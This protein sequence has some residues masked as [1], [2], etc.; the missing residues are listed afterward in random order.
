MN[1][2]FINN[3][4]EANHKS[5]VSTSTLP[6]MEPLQRLHNVNACEV[7]VL[8]CTIHEIIIN[9]TSTENNM[10]KQSRR[11]RERERERERMRGGVSD[12]REKF[13]APITA[14]ISVVVVAHYIK[15]G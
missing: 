6:L 14:I 3:I 12:R 11:E 13:D 15:R 4:T 10:S 2:Y 9:E 7:S 8:I 5:E 1:Q